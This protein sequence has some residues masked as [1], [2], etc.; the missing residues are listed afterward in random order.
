MTDA[1]RSLNAVNPQYLPDHPGHGIDQYGQTGNPALV[2]LNLALA[3]AGLDGPLTAEASPGLR[4]WRRDAGGTLIVPF[5]SGQTWWVTPEEYPAGTGR[6]LLWVEGLPGHVSAGLADQ[7][8]TVR[9][10]MTPFP[11][12]AHVESADTVRFTVTG[13]DLA[14]AGVAEAD[15]ETQGAFVPLNDDADEGAVDAAT[16]L[17]VKDRNAAGI[18]AGVALP[19]ER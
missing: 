16:G 8:V 1:P 17:P 10:G 12:A 6:P 18:A 15:E 9:F 2:P 11:G 4:L 5:A 14:V 13:V 19:V 7:W 3:T